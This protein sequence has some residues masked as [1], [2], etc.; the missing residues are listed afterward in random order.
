MAEITTTSNKRKN[1]FSRS[2]NRRS[3]RVDL[4]PMVDLGFLLITFF[5][6][7]TSMS[8]AKAMTLIEPK[9]DAETLVPASGA[10]TIIPGKD[11]QVW[12]YNGI[13][14]EPGQI[15]KTNFKDVRD[16]ILNKKNRTAIGDLMYIIKPAANS[17]FG[18]IIDLLDEMSICDIP[19][20][21]YSE[22][23]ITKV[24]SAIIKQIE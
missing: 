24:E 1:A 9:N 5:V 22:V 19:K 11:H 16:L 8:E 4:T 17:T 14:N 10:M 6:F 20:G 23:E 2:A 15:I 7:T 3:T 12:Y 21:H 13:L 18:D